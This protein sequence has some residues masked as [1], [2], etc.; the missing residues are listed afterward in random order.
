MSSSNP[1]KEIHVVREVG[2]STEDK[3]HKTTK[4]VVQT[5]KRKYS[6]RTHSDHK[7]WWAQGLIYK[8]MINLILIHTTLALTELRR[9]KRW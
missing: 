6:W 5:F 9:L 4:C 8:H 2:P 1:F 3:I 7:E